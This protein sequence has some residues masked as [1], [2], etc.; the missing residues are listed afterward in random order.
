MDWA[1]EV[2]SGAEAEIEALP[3]AIRACLLRLLETVENVGRP[4][5][6]HRTFGIWTASSGSFESRPKAVLC[7]ESI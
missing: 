4:R 7:G 6:V 2:I 1:V 3:V 5:F